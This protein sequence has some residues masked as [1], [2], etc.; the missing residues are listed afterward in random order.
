M[1]SWRSPTDQREKTSE[2]WADLDA[3]QGPDSAISAA[4]VNPAPN[5]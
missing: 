5:E 1:N 4:A 3:E 2:K